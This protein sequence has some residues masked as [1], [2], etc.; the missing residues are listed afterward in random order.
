MLNVSLTRAKRKLI[1]VGDSFT[2]SSSA[3]YKEL[4]EHIKNTGKYLLNSEI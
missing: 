1:V 4:I 3:I 2:L